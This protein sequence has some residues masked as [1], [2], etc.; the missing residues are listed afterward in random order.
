M[1][2]CVKFSPQS[3]K[4]RSMVPSFPQGFSLACLFPGALVQCGL[5]GKY[6]LT[7]SAMETTYKTPFFPFLLCQDL[8]K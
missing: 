8:G 6:S 7:M 3:E 1:P 2:G 4:R 5:L